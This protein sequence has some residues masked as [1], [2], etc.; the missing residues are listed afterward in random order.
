LH[1]EQHCPYLP[2]NIR[3]QFVQLLQESRSSQQHPEGTSRTSSSSPNSS[4]QKRRRKTGMSALLYY[5]ISAKRIGVQ[6]VQDGMRFG[7]DISL[8]PLPFATVQEQVERDYP[9]LLPKQPPGGGGSAAAASSSVLPNR[10]TSS[11]TS[12]SSTEPLAPRQAPDHDSSTVLADAM[13][14]LDDNICFLCKSSD[15]SLVTDYMFLAIRQMN[16]CRANREDFKKR[17]KKT[18][19]MRVGF[20][21]FA[22]RHCST[23][24]SFLSAADNLTSAVSTFVLHLIKC[25]RVSKEIKRA[26]GQLK[27]LHSQQLQSMPYGSQRQFFHQFWERLRQADAPRQPHDDDYRYDEQQQQ[28]QQ[29]QQ[30]SGDKEDDEHTPDSVPSAATY[31]VVAKPAVPVHD[32]PVVDMVV[33]PVREYA[34]ST[35]T[36]LSVSAGDVKTKTLLKTI[37]AEDSSLIL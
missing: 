29:Q 27:R 33:D 31:Q 6:E 36:A 26:L 5:T 32:V 24:R 7:R 9:Q 18:E 13:D 35:S 23:C 14:A 34:P 15:R 25:P 1:F 21:G 17:G 12:K 10:I 30:Q 28:Q 16:V 2:D 19:L 37:D 20:A 22:C 11:Y 4:P 8:A 3:Q